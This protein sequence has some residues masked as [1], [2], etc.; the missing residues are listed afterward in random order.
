MHDNVCVTLLPAYVHSCQPSLQVM[1]TA[2][3]TREERERG[4]KKEPSHTQSNMYPNNPSHG[5]RA[6]KM[7][8][9]GQLL[10]TSLRR[11]I[12]AKKPPKRVASATSS[13]P[14]G[15]TR[16]S[17]LPDYMFEHMLGAAQNN[18]NYNWAMNIIIFGELEL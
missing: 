8:S 1:S 17:W 12:Y 6:P 13:I 2:S 5:N 10:S 15:K 18:L 7:D 4:E 3:L 14:T 11:F 9:K 16:V